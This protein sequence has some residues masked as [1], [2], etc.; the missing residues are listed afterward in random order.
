[1][2]RK[3]RFW[4]K[5]LEGFDRVGTMIAGWE[6][7]SILAGLL[8]LPL[9]E[10]GL[11]PRSVLVLLVANLVGL[12]T[13]LSAWLITYAIASRRQCRA[14]GESVGQFVERQVRTFRRHWEGLRSAP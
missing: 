6:L 11:A 10:R 2:R 14:R 4:W 1:M 3:L 12:A 8:V 9:S 7:V 13:A 5:G